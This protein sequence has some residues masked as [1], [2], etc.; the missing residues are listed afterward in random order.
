MSRPWVSMG[1]CKRYLLWCIHFSLLRAKQYPW[2]VCHRQLAG[3]C[4]YNLYT[5]VTEILFSIIVQADTLHH[6]YHIRGIEPR[7]H[8]PCANRLDGLMRIPFRLSYPSQAGLAR[9]LIP[10]QAVKR[11]A[12]GNVDL[13][14]IVAYSVHD[15]L[16]AF[17]KNSSERGDGCE[18]AM[19]G[20]PARPS[21]RPWRRGTTAT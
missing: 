20:A 18:G 1:P 4:R 8:R 10:I 2:S 7:S 5:L 19:F 13:L 6:S 15:W 3:I 12:I 17:A 11:G 9:L 21:L 14:P 16:A